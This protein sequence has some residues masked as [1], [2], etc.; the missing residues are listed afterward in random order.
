MTATAYEAVIGLEVHV[1]LNTRSKIFCSCPTEFGAEPNTHVCPVCL[2]LPGVLPVLNEEAVR[3]AVQAA[4]ALNC[5]I[6]SY[7]KFDRKNYFYPDLP[8]AYQISEYDLP[9]AR[10]GWIELSGGKRIGIRRIHLEE[11]AGKLIHQGDIT[12][13]RFSLVD[14]NRCGVPLIE[15][16]S[17]PDIRT[18]EEA[19]EYLTRL[20]GILQHIGVSDC[21]M[22]EG[23]LRVDANVSVRPVGSSEFGTRTEIKNIGSFRS[24]YRGLAYEI[25]R[26]IQV[27]EDGGQVVQE[28]RHW[29]EQQGVT[30]SLRGKEEAQDYRYFPE[31]D[32]VPLLLDPEWVEEVRRSLPELPEARKARFMKEY[33][34]PAYDADVLVSSPRISDFFEE[35]VRQFGEPKTVSNWVMGELF[36]LLNDKGMEPEQMKVQP[37]QLVALLQLVKDGTIS[38]KIAKEVFEEMFETGEHPSSIVKKRDLVQISDETT[39]EAIVSRVVAE[40]PKVV[41]DYLSGKKQALAFL[42]GQV[43]KATKGKANPAMVNKLLQEKLK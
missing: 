1:E 30:K 33:G 34:L 10:N 4:L 22:E 32:L 25:E 8:K 11:D 27:L 24:V 9:L 29:D 36:R 6:M 35:C 40:N 41:N 38:G 39:L 37:D 17:E 15:I 43:M 14:Y 12:T 5:Q 13:A 21:K 19:R 26:Q 2:G 42:V 31:P 3:K 28:T 18:P 20:K 7:A 16:V 23:S